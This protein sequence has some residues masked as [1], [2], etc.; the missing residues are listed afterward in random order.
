MERNELFHKREYKQLPFSVVKRQFLFAKKK[1]KTKKEKNKEF[2][3]GFDC[4]WLLAI[5][6][7]YMGIQ[8]KTLVIHFAVLPLQ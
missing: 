2:L 4:Y 6:I 5:G 3:S 1:Q 7:T 8:L